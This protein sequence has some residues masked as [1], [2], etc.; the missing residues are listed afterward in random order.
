[1]LKGKTAI[2]TGASRGIG[3]AIALELA[4]QG[5]NIAAICVGNS[6]SAEKVCMECREQFGVRAQAYRCDVSSYGEAKE[7]T[8]QIRKEFGTVQIL[9]NNAG[10]TRDGLLAMMKE[11]DFDAVLNTNLKGAFNMIRHCT[12]LF[13]R[14]KEGCII[15]ITSE[16][17]RASCRERV[18]FCV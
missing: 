10:I 7:V 14:A 16:I 12:G 3:R 6:A 13:L 15:N 2:V 11:E 5:T 9:V 1:M 8:A 18:S 4:S 17:G